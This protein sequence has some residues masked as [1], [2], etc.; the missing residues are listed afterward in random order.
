MCMIN[1]NLIKVD[2]IRFVG[3]IFDGKLSFT[4]HYEDILSK[5]SR[6][7]RITIRS[8]HFIPNSVLNL[9][10]FIPRLVNGHILVMVL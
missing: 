6:V 8:R 5:L 7:A 1:I 2:K 9:F 4:Y 3:V 10:I